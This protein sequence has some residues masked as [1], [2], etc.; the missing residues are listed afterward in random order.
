MGSTRIL[1]LDSPEEVCNESN[2][3]PLD[4]VSRF[5]DGTL[6]ASIERMRASYAPLSGCF[7]FCGG[8][9]HLQLGP[10]RYINGRTLHA[11]CRPV[12]D[13]T[14]EGDRSPDLGFLLGSEK[15]VINLLR[16]EIGEDQ[17]STFNAGRD[18]A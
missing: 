8:A 10:L 6:A 5:D 9:L 17:A 16:L 7:G 15:Q 18:A 1:D 12:V 2:E 4:L 11:K 14:F 13:S 3:F